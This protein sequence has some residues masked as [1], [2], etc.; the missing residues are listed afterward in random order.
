MQPDHS[1]ARVCEF[2]EFFHDSL[3][4]QLSSWES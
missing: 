1:L 2:L 4:V 3:L